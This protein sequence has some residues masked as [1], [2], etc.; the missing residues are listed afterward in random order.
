MQLA[1]YQAKYGLSKITSFSAHDGS[2]S[3]S[4]SQLGSD[5]EREQHPLLVDVYLS[6]EM[7]FDHFFRYS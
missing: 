3:F 6:G 1:A 5:A 2:H 7:R 4:T